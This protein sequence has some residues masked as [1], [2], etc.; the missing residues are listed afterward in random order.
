MQRGEA[1]DDVDHS[2]FLGLHVGAVEGLEEGRP[3]RGG[4]I[5]AH[6]AG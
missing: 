1:P 3:S 4:T 6:G 2:G 5:E